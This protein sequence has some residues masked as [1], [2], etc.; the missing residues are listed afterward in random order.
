MDNLG[1]YLFIFFV[2]IYNICNKKSDNGQIY[3]NLIPRKITCTLLGFNFLSLLS[4]FLTNV[5]NKSHIYSWRGMWT[6]PCCTFINFLLASAKLKVEMS[7]MIRMK[8][9]LLLSGCLITQ[10]YQ[11]NPCKSVYVLALGFFHRGNCFFRFKWIL[12]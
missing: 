8:W 4:L 6:W 7:F 5:S 1:R 9:G 12:R 10:P 2:Y 11:H 3:W